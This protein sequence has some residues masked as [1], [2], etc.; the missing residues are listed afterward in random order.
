MNKEDKMKSLIVYY[1]RTGKTKKV[2]EFIKE[3]LNGEIEEITSLKNRN[4]ILGILLSIYESLFKKLT[5]IKEIEKDL[6]NYD[7]I[8]IGTPIWAGNFSSP[9]RTF[10]VK[11]KDILKTKDVI[12]FCTYG[13]E[14]KGDIKDLFRLV[15]DIEDMEIFLRDIIPIYEKDI[16]VGEFKDKIMNILKNYK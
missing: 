15:K 7:L 1:S 13:L 4:G 12:L 3:E 16:A 6:K 5:P 2:A 9:V 10:I 14:M 11:Y 8:V